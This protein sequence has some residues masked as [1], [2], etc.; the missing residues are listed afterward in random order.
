[1]TRESLHN[2]V[3]LFLNGHKCIFAFRQK[4]QMRKC[5]I[6]KNS[7]KCKGEFEKGNISKICLKNFSI[8]IHYF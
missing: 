4:K 8:K 2:F 5:E 6:E 1:M 7:E 3:C